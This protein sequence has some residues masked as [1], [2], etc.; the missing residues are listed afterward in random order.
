MLLFTSCRKDERITNDPQAKLSFYSTTISFD[1]VFTSIGSTAQRIRVLNKNSAALN[2]SE[3]KLAGGEASPFSININGVN[4]SVQKEIRLNGLDSLNLFIK[5]TI[6]PKA[7]NLPFLVEDSI[8]LTTNGNRQVL[9]LSAYG[10]NAVFIKDGEITGDITWDSSLPY[11]ITNSVTIKNGA[12]L[13]IPAK[14]KVYFHRDATM[15]IE[16]YL[17]AVGSEMQPIV[18]SSDRLETLYTEEPG[19]WNGLHF[20]ERGYGI[21]KNAVLKNALVGITADSLSPNGNPKL[22]LSNTLIKNMQVAAFMGFHSELYAFNNL[23]YNCGNYLMYASG[24]GNYIFKQ[25][26]FA[27][28]SN[29]LPRKTAA[30]SFSD[31]LSAKAYN[32]LQINLTNN[33]I[34]GSLANELEIEKRTSA[35]VVSQI[36]YNLIKTTATTFSGNGNILNVDPS[37]ISSDNYIFELQPTSVA[38]KKGVNLSADPYFPTYLKK[39]LNN[40]N[41][42]FPSSLGCYENY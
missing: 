35:S 42:L 16:G 23:I 21:I 34:W 17:N 25:N 32:N 37:F 40:K 38:I 27:G 5:V 13:T 19:Q 10:Q 18:F 2:I 22:I 15:Q 30:L 14:A 28:F 33:I 12:S 26:T 3:I 39:D 6:D 4:N 31:Y 1:T 36:A 11:I 8:I 20:K 29:S 41:R 9:K 24:G 7:S